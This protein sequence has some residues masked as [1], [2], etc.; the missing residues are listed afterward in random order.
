[1]NCP[2]KS[3]SPWSAV[4][5]RCFFF[6][7]FFFFAEVSVMTSERRTRTGCFPGI[8]LRSGSNQRYS[9]SIWHYIVEAEGSRALL[10]LLSSKKSL[11]VEVCRC[12]AVNFCTNLQETDVK[13]NVNM[14]ELY[15][16]LVQRKSKNAVWNHQMRKD[17]FICWWSVFIFYITNEQKS[18]HHYLS[19]NNGSL[20]SYYMREVH[21]SLVF[22]IDFLNS[23]SLNKKRSCYQPSV[24]SFFLSG[25]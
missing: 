20:V 9:S 21:P 17:L 19:N 22:F 24:M 3:N 16:M 11:C 14:D 4:S 8:T 23:V 15:W 6:L 18:L 25:S 5:A 12:G 13:V 7:F 1:M 2:F 10:H